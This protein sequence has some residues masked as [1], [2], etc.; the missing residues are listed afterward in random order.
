MR[1]YKLERNT[2]ETKVTVE[3]NLD[4]KGQSN[5]DTGIGFFDHMLTLFSFHGSF[6]LNIKCDG[7]LHVD[8]HHTVEDIGIT[9]GQ[10]FFRALGEK[11]GINR[12][13]TFYV[14]MDEALARAV[15]DISNRPY[16]VYDVQLK[17]S[18]LGNMDTQNFKEFFRAFV[19]ESRVTLHLCALYGDNDHHIIE[20]VFKAFG[21]ALK[22]AVRIESDKVPSTKGIL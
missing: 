10:A 22:E 21:R 4:G 8:G 18:K 2:F 6:D 11:K 17:N 3:I 16:L 13:G 20:S 5:I 9:L 14:P 1:K 15:V 12:F 7:D 19:N